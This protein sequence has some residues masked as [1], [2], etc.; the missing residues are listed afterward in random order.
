MYRGLKCIGFWVHCTNRQVEQNNIFSQISPFLCLPTELAFVQYGWLAGS[1]NGE[2][3]RENRSTTQ[4]VRQMKSVCGSSGRENNIIMWNT[5]GAKLSIFTVRTTVGGAQACLR[6]A[7]YMVESI[8]CHVLFTR[9]LS[10]TLPPHPLRL[11]QLDVTTF[12]S[13]H[14]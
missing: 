13:V 6:C 8:Q 4:H 10:S 14:K 7:M 11:L 2:L 3:E 9:H 1:I 5:F 12:C